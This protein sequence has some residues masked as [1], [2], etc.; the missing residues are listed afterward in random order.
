MKVTK[1]LIILAI[2]FQ[3][4]LQ[5]RAQQQAIY[6]QYMFNHVAIN[7]AYAAS[8]QSPSFMLLMRNQWATMEGAP[9]SGMFTF[10][11][12]FK[13]EKL[14]LGVTLENDRVGPISETGVFADIAYQ[15]KLNETQTLAFGLKAGFGFNKAELTKLKTIQG[16]DVAFSEDIYNYFVPNFG[17]GVFYYSP[18]YYLGFSVPKFIQHNTPGGTSDYSNTKELRHFYLIGGYVFELNENL[19]FKPS[20]LAKY[21]KSAPVSVDLTASFLF[22]ERLWLG[23]SYRYGD[24]LCGMLELKIGKQWL[25]GYSFDFATTKLVRYNY[26]THEILLS[27]ELNFSKRRVKSPRYF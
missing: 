4:G 24:A 27:Y 16:N 17:A 8:K 20:F 19:K 5:A 13:K 6:T 22:Y 12:P 25:V 21:V 3:I 10:H 2:L 11:T 23:A 18:T 7:P 15:I 9:N 26:G 1:P 14:G